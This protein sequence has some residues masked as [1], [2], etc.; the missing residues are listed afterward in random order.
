[1]N[2]FIFN[3]KLSKLKIFY[4]YLWTNSF[5]FFHL[6]RRDI[7]RILRFLRGRIKALFIPFYLDRLVFFILIN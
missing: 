6:I 4:L 2:K 5:F 3:E 1:M 7:L